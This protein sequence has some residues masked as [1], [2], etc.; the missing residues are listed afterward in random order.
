MISAMF[1]SH[2]PPFQHTIGQTNFSEASYVR[3]PEGYRSTADSVWV[4]RLSVAVSRE[5]AHLVI[6]F[7]SRRG[8]FARILWEAEHRNAIPVP[9]RI[10]YPVPHP[11][12]T[13]GTSILVLLIVSANAGAAGFYG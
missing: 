7:P 13:S 3:L 2:S 5:N 6:A 10:L 12:S 8:S 11:S 4:Q 9:G 1:M